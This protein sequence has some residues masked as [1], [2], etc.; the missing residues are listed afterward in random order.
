MKR[1]H[2]QTSCF[3]HSPQSS[4][5]AVKPIHAT[6]DINHKPQALGKTL[7]SSE[8]KEQQTKYNLKIKMKER[9]SKR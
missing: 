6:A 7:G 9:L 4:V 1:F 8:L 3:H 2:H 5:Q